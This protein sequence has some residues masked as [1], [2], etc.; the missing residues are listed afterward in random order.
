MLDN[1]QSKELKKSRLKPHQNN[2]L[3]SPLQGTE[4][5]F[6]ELALKYLRYWWVFLITI[7]VLMSAAYVYVKRQ[8]RVYTVNTKVLLGNV[9]DDVIPFQE[10]F[11]GG[12]KLSVKNQLDDEMEVIVSYQMLEKTVANLDFLVSY[13]TEG[14][15]GKIREYYKSLPFVVE[16]DSSHSQLIAN[17]NLK[18]RI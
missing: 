15:W 13:Y 10:M 1:F 7:I 16:I 2:S 6:Q 18:D 11:T 14:E 9:K 5:Q 8:H 12:S 4:I 17:Y 3:S